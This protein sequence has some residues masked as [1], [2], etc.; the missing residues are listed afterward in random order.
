MLNG[1]TVGAAYVNDNI[2]NNYIMS[3]GATMLQL[4]ANAVSLTSLMQQAIT[5]Q[6][7]A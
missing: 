6:Q 3:R 7:T 1:A 2:H 4:S 5:A